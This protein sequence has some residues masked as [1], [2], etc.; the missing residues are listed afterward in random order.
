MSLVKSPILTAAK[1]AANR[2]NA[3]RSTG[4]RSTA[5][6][7]RVRLNGLKHGLRSRSFAKTVIRSARDKER[8]GRGVLLLR[9]A[10]VPAGTG[11]ASLVERLSRM[12][13]TRGRTAGPRGRQPYFSLTNMERR[14]LAQVVR[15]C[16]WWH[17]D[18]AIYAI[19]RA[20]PPNPRCPLESIDSSGD[21]TL[22][23]IQMP[24]AHP[25]ILRQAGKRMAKAVLGFARRLAMYEAYQ[26]SRNVA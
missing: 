26:Q 16:S 24:L 19:G 21:S 8:F 3:C 7:R 11:A 18:E 17:A 13:W 2:S 22:L 10:F 5:G 9:L 14:L 20:L 6:K 12:M 15:V 25:A 23:Q 1:L 4:P